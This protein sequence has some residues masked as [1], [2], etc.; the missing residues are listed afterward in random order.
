MNNNKCNRFN[1]RLQAPNGET[2]AVG[3]GGALSSFRS[4]QAAWGNFYIS[5]LIDKTLDIVTRRLPLRV[6]SHNGNVYLR[7]YYVL[8]RLAA[9]YYP[10][11]TKGRSRRPSQASLRHGECQRHRTRSRVSGIRVGA[12]RRGLTPPLPSPPLPIER[13]PVLSRGRGFRGVS[14]RPIPRHLRVH[15]WYPGQLAYLVSLGLTPHHDPGGAVPRRAVLKGALLVDA[16]LQDAVLTN[17]VLT[18]TDL[19]GT[20]LANA[21]LTNTDL[22]GTDLA[23]ADL[24]NAILRWADLRGAI[25]QDAILQDA[26]LQDAILVGADLRGTDLDGAILT[27]ARGIDDVPRAPVPGLAARVLR[28]ITEHPESHDQAVWHSA[29]QARHCCAGWAILLAGSAGSAAEARLGTQHAAALLLGGD[30]HPFGA[31][32]DP[33]PWLRRRAAEESAS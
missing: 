32:N 18:N 17:A 3:K 1:R 26:I 5:K 28:Q 6:I 9:A 15:T 30:D 24:T 14:T 2:I 13:S 27:G 23:N 33:I 20:D 19:R 11:G 4:R 21:D 8:G 16:D 25:L 7:R 12:P 31:D 10:D 29:C 22:R